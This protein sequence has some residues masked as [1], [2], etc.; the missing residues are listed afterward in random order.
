M[1]AEEH[2]TKEGPQEVG[3]GARKAVHCPRR[4]PKHLN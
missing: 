3:L 2:V 4:G 1:T